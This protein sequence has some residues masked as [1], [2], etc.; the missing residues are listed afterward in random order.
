MTGDPM[1]DPKLASWVEHYTVFRHNGRP[2]AVVRRFGQLLAQIFEERARDFDADDKVPK[3]S[4]REE[5]AAS[6][7]RVQAE[8]AKA[9]ASSVG[10]MTDDRK[11]ARIAMA[12]FANVL[13]DSGFLEA[14]REVTREM[15]RRGA[16]RAD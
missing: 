1:N 4:A 9:L 15:K 6:I 7:L 3:R 12:A 10:T 13:M 8:R 2:D 16:S 11:T 14:V 5:L